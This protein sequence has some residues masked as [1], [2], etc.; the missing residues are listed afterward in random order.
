VPVGPPVPVGGTP[1]LGTRRVFSEDLREKGS[2]E[3][4]G[5]HSGT[6]VHV[7]Q[8]NM[9]LCHAGWTLEKVGPG[10]GKTGNL[11]AGGLLDFAAAPPAF[12]A[13]FGGTRDFK[14]ARGEI[15]AA[16]VAGTA[17]QEWDY[18]VE[19]IL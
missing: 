5:Q 19:I 12:V 2:S 16:P 4:I 8:P 11:V 15:E 6:C 1:D 18:K 7:R 13:I 3:V 14:R 9:C 10:A 17:P